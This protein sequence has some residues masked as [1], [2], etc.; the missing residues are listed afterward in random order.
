MEECFLSLFLMGAINPDPDLVQPGVGFLS[1]KAAAL[2][3]VSENSALP[4]GRVALGALSLRQ[5]LC[6][7]SLRLFLGDL[8]G[9]PCPFQL[10]HLNVFLLSA[11]LCSA[12]KCGQNKDGCE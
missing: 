3:V 4:C 12:I 7:L 9:L 2:L 10:L 6:L 5:A 8:F 1:A 11:D